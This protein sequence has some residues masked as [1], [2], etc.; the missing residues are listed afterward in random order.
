MIIRLVLSTDL[1]NHF[2]YIARLNTKLDSAAV[3]KPIKSSVDASVHGKP[4]NSGKSLPCADLDPLTLMET[5]MKMSDVANGARG[6]KTY[7]EWSARVF[8]EFY[9]QGDQEVRD[10]DIFP[11]FAFVVKNCHALRARACGGALE[12][13]CHHVISTYGRARPNRRGLGSQYRRSWIALTRRNSSVRLHSSNTSS[14]L[15]TQW[16]SES[17]QICLH[18]PSS[19]RPTIES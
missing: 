12:F 8:E 9:L 10:T 3:A 6:S 15:C 5:A 17:G 14:G 19:W 18:P 7:N 11:L 16:E 2:D 13:Y 4:S 1:A